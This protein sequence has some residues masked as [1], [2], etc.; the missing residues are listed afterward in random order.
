M[1][2]ISVAGARLEAGAAALRT[3]LSE[4][5]E[6][7]YARDTALSPSRLK[8]F[9]VTDVAGV[10]PQD[11]APLQP[12]SRSDVEG[13]FVLTLT[14]PF[15]EQALGG[16]T[17]HLMQLVHAVHRELWRGELAATATPI[18]TQDALV[19]QFAPIATL[20]LD[21][22]RA[23]RASTWSLPGTAD[24]LLP[25]LLGL[26][27]ELPDAGERTL[28]AYRND[29]DLDTLVG[30]SMA[31]LTHLMQTIAFSL[32]YLAGLGRTA[33]DIAPELKA[34]IDASIIGREWPRIAALLSGA[35]A[36]DGDARTLQLNMLRTRIIAVLGGMGLTVGLDDGRCIWT[37]AEGMTSDA[38]AHHRLLH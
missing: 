33:G 32:G 15:V 25:H 31:R 16:E 13:G 23:N 20:M 2:P 11:A 34:G 29:G 10:T 18:G 22:Y 7:L 37:P 14:A 12:L 30:L 35:A 27:D 6:R 4:L 5:L 28:A 38:A 9:V 3:T 8:S 21:E 19:A 17:D 1:F 24:L 26:L 36:S